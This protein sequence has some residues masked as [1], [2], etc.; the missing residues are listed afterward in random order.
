[1][2]PE[3][4]AL[5]NSVVEK[6]FAKETKGKIEYVGTLTQV[7][8]QFVQSHQFDQALDKIEEVRDILSTLKQVPTKNH[9]MLRIVCLTCN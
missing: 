2:A 4:T 8:T 1:M 5:Y 9:E 3:L 7:A 6:K